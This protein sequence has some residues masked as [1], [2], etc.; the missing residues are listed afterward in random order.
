M[1]TI[2]IIGAGMGGLAAAAELA[3]SGADVLVIEAHEDVGG[4]LGRA[5]VDG[6][7][8]DT[9]PSVLTMPDVVSGLFEAA[10]TRLED[11]LRLIEEDVFE[12]MWPD[13][14]RLP[15]AF[16]REDTVDHVRARLGEDAAREFAE[17]LEYAKSI[18]D[19]A[20]PNFVYGDAPTVGSA[21]KLGVTKFRELMKID[22]MRAMASSI[23]SRVSHP[24]LRDILLRY[25]TYNGSDP[26]SAPATL[27][28]IAWVEL[29]LGCYGVEGG[30]FELARALARVASR[31]GARFRMST[32]VVSIVHGRGG[33][34]AVVLDNGERIDC[35]HVVCNADVAHLANDLMPDS[36]AVS[37]PDEPSMSGWNAVIKARRRERPGHAVLF[38][39][40]SY[41]E[42]FRDIFERDRPPTEP[43]V[44]VCAQEKAH[45]RQGWP[46]HEALFV[47]ANAPPEPIDGARDGGIWANLE[48]IVLGRLREHD[49]IEADDQVVWRRT[50]S[51]LARQF[52][53]SRGAIYGA[54]SNS[55]FAAFQRPANRVS[56][57]SGLYLASGS[58]HPG[59]G[60]PLCM[61]SGRAAARAILEDS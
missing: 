12:Y 28:C 35:Q 61:L 8:F 31:H 22:P 45:H 34:E 20:A 36:S 4:K 43:T 56:K 58:A 14:T 13:G 2:V 59:G 51:D 54:A 39:E 16:A 15:V 37:P 32:R 46:E 60:V 21:M 52:R 17:F 23:E 38:C 44:Y 25:A 6:V 48:H 9:G 57:V 3:A 18:W 5:E 49:L 10:G 50:P 41:R 11:E 7:E 19:A 53:G 27:N 24:K 30:M 40:R 33:V 55:Q 42:E 26:W 29:G 47:M 1:S